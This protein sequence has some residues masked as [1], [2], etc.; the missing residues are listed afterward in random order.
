MCPLR[1][2]VL[3]LPVRFFWRYG[4]SRND[5]NPDDTF[6][7]PSA[8]VVNSHVRQWPTYF[9]GFRIILSLIFNLEPNVWPQKIAWILR[10]HYKVLLLIPEGFLCSSYSFTWAYCLYCRLAGLCSGIRH[11][12]LKAIHH[13]NTITSWLLYSTE[14]I[15][16]TCPQLAAS[17]KLLNCF[18]CTCCWKI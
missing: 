1:P 17:I 5:W 14:V 13:S 8:L 9:K 12:N 3:S 7:H 16:Q 6:N 11:V 4:S 18:L 2:H 10:N 15:L